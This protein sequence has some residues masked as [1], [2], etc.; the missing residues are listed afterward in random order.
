MTKKEIIKR[1]KEIKVRLT[2]AEH[3]ALLERMTGGELATWIRS[4][5]LDEKPNKKRNYKAADP[6]L[7]AALGRIGGNLNQIARQV[8]TVESDIEKL[9][10]FA[11]LAV[12][13][14]QLQGILANYDR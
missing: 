7:L 14:E 5:C 6:Q 3:Q 1:K 4:T 2:E 9:R 13:R 12:I 8:N 10:A 11:E